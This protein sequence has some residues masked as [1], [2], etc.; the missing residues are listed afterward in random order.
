MKVL[1]TGATGFLGAGL[2]KHLRSLGHEVTA[3]CRRPDQSS[4]LEDCDV[5]LKAMDLTDCEAVR[6]GLLDIRPQAVIHCAAY[7]VAYGQHDPATAYAANVTGTE[8]LLQA[9]T[10]VSVQR[11]VHI[12]S[13]FEYGHYDHPIRESD[14]L[15]PTAVYGVTKAAASRLALICANA[16]QIPLLVVRPFGLWG[17]REDP[18]RLVPSVLRACL[19]QRPLDLTAGQQQRDYLHLEDATEMILALLFLGDFP[20]RAIINLGS[21]QPVDLRTFVDKIASQLGGRD[22]MRFG[23]R[24]YRPDE[25]MSL[26]PDLTRLRSLLP[27]AS[28]PDRFRERID[29]LAQDMR[30]HLETEMQA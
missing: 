19:L 25:M 6:S 15:R 12:G 5:R 8:N 28:P 23:N 3:T 27:T 26:V 13:C 14:A 29:A 2:V 11:F 22:L 1:V 10:A 21:G 17:P 16:W 4:R 30:R 7:G 18:Q 9:A 20:G 24:P